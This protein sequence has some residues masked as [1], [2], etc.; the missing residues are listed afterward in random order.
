MTHTSTPMTQNNPSVSR[1]IL[2][3]FH[4]LCTYSPHVICNGTNP[5]PHTHLQRFHMPCFFIGLFDNGEQNLKHTK[6]VF[7][8]SRGIFHLSNNFFFHM[9]RRKWNRPKL[10]LQFQCNT[11]IIRIFLLHK[12][13]MLCEWQSPKWN[14]K[15]P[16]SY[17]H[18][19]VG[20]ILRLVMSPPRQP[21]HLALIMT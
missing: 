13:I 6:K 7:F 4:H 18:E 5:T 9:S 12:V 15:G 16:M 1:Q 17:N 8:F 21:P 10:N 11:S 3:T 20:T 19:W 2:I 14:N